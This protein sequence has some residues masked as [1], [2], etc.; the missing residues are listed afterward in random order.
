MQL[1]DLIEAIETA[2]RLKQGS[3][4]HEA[5]LMACLMEDH[6]PLPLR[7]DAVIRRL[8]CEHSS[9]VVDVLP[10]VWRRSQHGIYV[11]ELSMDHHIAA[12]RWEDALEW[13]E[14]ARAE[15]WTPNAM[16]AQRSKARHPRR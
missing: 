14:T 1:D 8:H 3:A 10:E 12:V 7:R 11:P 9:R 5:H 16:K 13:L 4:W 15:A 6:G 2:N